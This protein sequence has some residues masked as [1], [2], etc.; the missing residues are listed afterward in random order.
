MSIT[1]LLFPVGSIYYECA[2][3]KCFYLGALLKYDEVVL[4]HVWDSFL[5]DLTPVAHCPSCNEPM[6]IWEDDE[7]AST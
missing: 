6:M 3:D 5:G 7:N 1:P 2:N 4:R